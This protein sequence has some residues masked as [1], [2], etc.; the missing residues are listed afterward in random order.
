MRSAIADFMRGIASVTSGE[1]WDR[2]C[3]RRA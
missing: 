3:R 2:D 1:D